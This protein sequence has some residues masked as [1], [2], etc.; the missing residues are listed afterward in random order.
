MKIILIVLSIV[1]GFGL[2]SSIY[3]SNSVG[4]G[5]A[6]SKVGIIVLAVL[7]GVYLLYKRNSSPD[8]STVETEQNIEGQ[9][10]INEEFLLKKIKERDLKEGIEN[11]SESALFDSGRHNYVC[12]SERFKHDNTKLQQVTT[13][14]LDF[15]ELL[16][17]RVYE[18][19]I[20]HYLSD[21]DSQSHFNAREEI[22]TRLTEIN[23]RFKNLL[24][25]DY[26]DVIELQKL[27]QKEINGKVAEHNIST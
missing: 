15:M 2:I 21:E 6:D 20:L 10:K 1:Q 4:L 18:M 13:D 3:L 14:W 26:W 16:S 11:S 5:F 27:R 12:L 17:D 19:E 22:D 23:K 8:I 25:D 24:G 7:W 9:I